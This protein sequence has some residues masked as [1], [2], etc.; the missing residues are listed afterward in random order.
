MLER[1][2]G[3]LRL[4]VRL[5]LIS[6]GIGAALSFTSGGP[7]PAELLNGAAQGALIGATL[8]GLEPLC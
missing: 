1:T 3:R 7:R 4:V 6:A 5:T 8:T 2:K